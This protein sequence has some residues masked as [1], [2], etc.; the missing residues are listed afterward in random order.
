MDGLL[1]EDALVTESD[2]HVAAAAT[3]MTPW[4]VPCCSVCV[5]EDR[6]T[7]EQCASFLKTHSHLKQ[8]H[9][10]PPEVTMFTQ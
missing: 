3:T 10:F 6:Q 2:T 7:E 4:N 1:Q 5:R 9:S 8:W